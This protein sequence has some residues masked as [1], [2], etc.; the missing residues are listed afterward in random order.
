[1]G[2]RFTVEILVALIMLGSVGGILYGV[3]KG[4][5][6]LSIRTL[7]FLAIATV[8]PAVLILS[9]ERSI[10]NESTAALLGTIVGFV[11]AGGVK[12]E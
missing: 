12:N 4:T 3:F 6:V 11:L 7:Q 8:I 10:G 2:W 1:M 9:L 5:I